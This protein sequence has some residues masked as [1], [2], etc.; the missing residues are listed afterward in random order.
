M[1]CGVVERFALKI[2][3]KKHSAALTSEFFPQAS[4]GVEGVWTSSRVQG[5]HVSHAN[6]LALLTRSVRQSLTSEA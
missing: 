6:K 5:S 2:K 3:R 4:V 1:E